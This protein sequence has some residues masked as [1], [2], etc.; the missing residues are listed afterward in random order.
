MRLASWVVRA[1]LGE[2]A[3]EALL[4]ALREEKVKSSKGAATAEVDGETWL[5]GWKDGFFMAVPKGFQGYADEYKL[6][7]PISSEEELLNPLEVR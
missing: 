3:K 7:P 2:K 1:G 6:I 4:Q 5:V